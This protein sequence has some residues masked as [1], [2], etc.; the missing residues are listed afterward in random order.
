MN[1]M[2]M[3]GTMTRTVTPIGVVLLALATAGCGD[4]GDNVPAL[5]V[6]Y[7]PDGSLVVVTGMGI[8]IYDA[9]MKHEKRSIP[10][11]RLAPDQPAGPFALSRD[12]TV[13][14]IG[15][16]Q[17][18]I[19]RIAIPSGQVLNTFEVDSMYGS[20][21]EDLGLSEHGDLIFAV[22]PR[23]DAPSD[24]PAGNESSVID[25][26]TGRRLWATGWCTLPVFSRDDAVVYAQCDHGTTLRAFDAHSGA[27]VFER[28]FADQGL[29]GGLNGLKSVGGGDQLVGI[30]Y[31]PAPD[32]GCGGPCPEVYPVWSAADGTL[33]RTRP[34]SPPGADGY[35]TAPLGFAAFDCQAD[36]DLCANGLAIGV[37][38]QDQ[39]TV[40]TVWTTD[41]DTPARELK[42]GANDLALSADGN[43]MAM[44]GVGPASAAAVVNLANGSV[45]TVRTFSA[46]LF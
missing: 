17:K 26:A 18:K 11:T 16:Q 23:F 25:A 35:G 9:E 1:A 36:G 6:A 38:M 12:G 37:G 27:V 31:L 13:A 44:A 21:V 3:T 32:S 5:Y 39:Y 28:T 14:A 19:A 43:L 45:V 15:L 34:S 22:G 40:T 41:D 46:G 8:K 10:F 30:S 4:L 20:D 29:A 33:L 2:T 42:L 24:T 7:P